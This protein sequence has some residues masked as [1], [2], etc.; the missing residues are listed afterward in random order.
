MPKS[1]KEWQAWDD[2]QALAR[3]KMIEADKDRYESAKAAARKI[4]EEKKE[5]TDAMRKV[6]GKSGSRSKGENSQRQNPPSGVESKTLPSRK[7]GA[8]KTTSGNNY[9]VFKR[10]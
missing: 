3:A 8:S 7:R 6:A 4:V 10:I 5:E 2:A 1:E 9:N